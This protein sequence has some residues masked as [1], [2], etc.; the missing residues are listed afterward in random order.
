M[1]HVIIT[2]VVA[3]VVL[4]LLTFI[5]GNKQISQLNTFD[6]IIGI[7]IGN[8]TATMATAEEENVFEQLIAM[9]VI[10][11]IS[12]LVSWGSMKSIKMR[13]VFTGRSVLLLDNG[14]IY[15]ENFKKCKLD[16]SEFLVQCRQSGYFDVSQIQTAVFEANGQISIMPKS[17]NRPVTTQDLQIKTTTETPSVVL[18]QD[19]VLLN[20]NLRHTGND[21]QWLNAQLK[22][23]GINKVTDVFLASCDMNNVLTAFV[24]LS[25]T[26][27]GDIFM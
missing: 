18:I 11:L 12:L 10:V 25:E 14:K 9:L 8:L 5:L 26:A 1:I 15:R 7:T 27:P 22:K 20:E 17:E 2:S 4:F 23:L 13:R 24:Q 19:G 16:I 3:V 6:Y 21:T